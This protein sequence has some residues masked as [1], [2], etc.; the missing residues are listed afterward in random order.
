MEVDDGQKQENKLKNDSAHGKGD[1]GIYDGPGPVPE[2]IS[3]SELGKASER[4]V[5]RP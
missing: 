5:S 1:S 2:V 3:Y 4:V